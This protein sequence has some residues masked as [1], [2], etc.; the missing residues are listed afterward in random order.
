MKSKYP[1]Q[2]IDLRFQTG[3]ISP[4][5]IQL[6]EEYRLDPA[7][8]RLYVILIRRKEIE[9]SSDGNKLIEDLLGYRPSCKICCQ[10][11]YYINQDRIL[12]NRKIYSKN[13]RSKRDAYERQKR[14]TD[15]NFKLVCNMRG[16]TNRALK[17][18][19]VR[20]INKKFDLIRCSDSFFRK[21]DYSSTLR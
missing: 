4:N 13:N 18:Q 16:R 2:V 3:H 1:I 19:N 10:K 8:A 11:Y 14:L 6:F 21:M 5:K 20:N 7:N 15:L 12:N 9:F 17:T